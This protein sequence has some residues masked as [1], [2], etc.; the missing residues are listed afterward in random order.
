MSRPVA[1]LAGPISGV[2]H[3]GC[4]GWRDE[5][6][7][8]LEPA[9]VAA[10]SPMRDKHYLRDRGVL[11]GDYPER[12][13]STRDGIMT[14]DHFDVRNCDLV[15]ANLLGAARVSVGTVMELAW[16]FAYR[17]PV[18][19]VLEDGNV[20]DHPMV[21]AAVG[22]RVATLAEAAAVA[23]SVL[24]PYAAAGRAG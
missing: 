11:E 20:H 22:F 24:G 10:A 13:L 6:A 9:G 3:A 12:V 16:A 5:L 23:A 17:K 7:R 1:Y 8:L 15:V 4:T 14:R 18:V 19:A 2:T 21:R